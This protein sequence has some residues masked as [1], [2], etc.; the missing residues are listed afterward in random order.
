LDEANTR[1]FQAVV[2]ERPGY[3]KAAYF[4]VIFLPFGLVLASFLVLLKNKTKDSNYAIGMATLNIAII[5]ALPTF[6]DL[7]VPENIQNPL[8]INLSLFG[9]LA[10]SLLLTGIMII[11]SWSFQSRKNLNATK[12]TPSKSLP[13]TKSTRQ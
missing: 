1:A 10:F 13:N 12:T 6:K 2:I 9:L 5:L 3:I 11:L 8:L 4:V 7:L